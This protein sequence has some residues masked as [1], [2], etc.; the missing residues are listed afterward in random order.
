MYDFYFGAREK[1]E[2]DE[3]SFLLGIKRNLPRWCNG[4][5]DSEFLAVADILNSMDLQGQ[6]PV[7]IETGTGAST[8][9]LMHYA[10]K[11]EGMLYSW[12][13]N[14][15]KGAFLRGVITDTLLNFHRKNLHDHWTFVAFNSMSAH[16]GIPILKE[17]GR[18][19]CFCFFDSEHTLDVL[20][21]E[22]HLASD[23]AAAECVMAIDDANYTYR[24]INH[25]YINLFRTKLGLPPLPHDPENGCEPFYVETE[26]IL[27]ERWQG[28]EHISDSYKKHFRKD[29]FWQ[30]YNLDREALDSVEESMEKISDLEHRFDA[31]RVWR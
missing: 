11:F 25:A 9:V 15:L 8:I 6:R 7:F 12:D 20:S 4:I 22:I 13:I 23:V 14:S 16:L 29:I 5:P 30:Y 26:K 24:H 28:V 17:M 18:R 27:K 19:A 2:K 1:I 3:K 10:L 31:W 21:R